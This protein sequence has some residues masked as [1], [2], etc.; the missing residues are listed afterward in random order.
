MSYDLQ[1]NSEGWITIKSFESYVEA[2]NHGMEK[3]IQNEWRIYDSFRDSFNY[4]YFPSMDIVES[5]K[6]DFIR[7]SLAKK[8]TF[9]KKLTI[10]KRWRLLKEQKIQNLDWVREGF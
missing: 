1:L 5:R 3:Y 9:R 8:S 10:Q 7:F 6:V 2:K 4:Y